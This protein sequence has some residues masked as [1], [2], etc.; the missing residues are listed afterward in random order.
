M[1]G[2]NKMQ[3]WKAAVRIWERGGNNAPEKRQV[4]AQQY[5]Q[6]DY[7]DEQEKAFERMVADIQRLQ[8]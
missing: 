1:V 6:R 2:K 7:A 8:A 5:G 4:T 3:D